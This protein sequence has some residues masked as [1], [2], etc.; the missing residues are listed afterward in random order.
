LVARSRDNLTDGKRKALAGA[1]VAACAVVLYG[2]VELADYDVIEV[3]TGRVRLVA[4]VAVAILMPAGVAFWSK[5]LKSAALP[6]ASLPSALVI[7]FSTRWRSAGVELPPVG[8]ALAI[9]I[10]VGVVSALVGYGARAALA[11]ARRRGAARPWPRSKP[12][13]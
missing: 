8:E 9:F 12:L 1:G 13:A 3:G 11:R 7:Q 5:S 10:T 4:R 2:L 6:L